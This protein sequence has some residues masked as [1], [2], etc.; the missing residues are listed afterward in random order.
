MS[1]NNKS[2]KLIIDIREKK[3]IEIFDKLKDN[4]N[5]NKNNLVVETKQL[6]L[7]DFIFI[8]ERN[9]CQDYKEIIIFERKTVP[10]L[11][12]SIKDGRYNEQSFR[13]NH[14]D[15]IHNHN[16][17]YI[18][19]GDINNKKY[20]K[21]SKKITSRTVWSS[22]TSLLLFKGFSLNKTN[23]IDET[24]DFISYTCLKCINNFKANKCFF[25]DYIEERKNDILQDVNIN[26]TTSNNNDKNDD[27]IN[28]TFKNNN[29]INI[30]MKNNI[31]NNNTNNISYCHVVKKV[32]KQNITKENIGE[33]ILSQIPGI[34]ST[35]AI[36]LMEQFGSLFDLLTTLKNNPQCLNNLKIKCN[37]NKERKIS[38]SAILSIKKY[39][40]YSKQN[41]DKQELNIDI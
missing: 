30:D 39:L 28:I 19:E 31:N 21:F 40:L 3:A 35:I 29:D 6:D 36:S 27:K 38:S 37:N 2:Y 11:I 15:K 23:N 14:Y 16:I 18:I 25:Y 12:S 20:Y 34:S 10:D 1:N 5:F 24:C 17:I 41:C 8:E 26:N 33:I 22:L 32:K 4:Y 9:D 13:L 7:G